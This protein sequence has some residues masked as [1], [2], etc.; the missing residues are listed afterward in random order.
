M[1]CQLRRKGK[2]MGK[3]PTKK[4]DLTEATKQVITLKKNLGKGIIAI[5]QWL[6]LVK[7]NIPKG[8]W[9]DWLKYDAQ[10]PYVTAWRFIKI[11]QEIDY[12]TLERVGPSKVYEILNLP[13]DKFREELLEMAEGL[14]RE[15]IRIIVKEKKGYPPADTIEKAQPITADADVL[16]DANA[17]LR[18]AIF[19]LNLKVDDL[20]KHYLDMMA[21]QLRPVPQ[22]LINFIQKLEYAIRKK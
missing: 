14:K 8:E 7:E 11:S 22:E 18:D 16:L 3:L 17:T 5:G 9:L 21:N 19:H 10:I 15:D 12:P 1:M 2:K 13:A 20:P 4:F 6:I